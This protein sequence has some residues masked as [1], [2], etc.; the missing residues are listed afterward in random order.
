MLPSQINEIYKFPFQPMGHQ[1]ESLDA[2]YGSDKWGFYIF[3]GGG[4][5]Y[6]ATAAAL[7]QIYEGMAERCIII[8]PPILILQWCRWLKE[9]GNLNGGFSITAYKG[10]PKQREKLRLDSDFTVMSIQIFKRD[11]ARIKKQLRK[12]RVVLIVD[13]AQ[14]VRNVSTKNFRF[15]RDSAIEHV[16]YLLSGT[17]LNSPIN[18]Y[19]LIKLVT[20]DLYRSLGAFKN[21]HVATEDFWGAPKTYQNLDLLKSN[22]ELGATFVDAADA[23]D[24]PE[25]T[26]TPIVYDLAPAHMKLYN[27]LVDEEM[28]ILEDE[29][30]DA[31]QAMKLYHKCQELVI[32]PADFSDGAVKISAAF[33][34][35]DEILDEIGN[36][37]IIIF[38]HHR[39]SNSNI[40]THLANK[41]IKAVGVYGVNTP[42]VN[43]KNVDNFITDDTVQCLVA[44]TKSG[45][46]G[47]NL[48]VARY[49][50]FLECPLTSNDFQQTIARI[51][52]TGQKNGCTVWLII[53]N[54]T[55]QA[56]IARN[57][58]NRDEV[59][60]EVVQSKESISKALKGVV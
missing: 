21:I 13:E 30:V 29:V 58:T 26:Y 7:Y 14:M 1:I 28:L 52:R 18:A 51:H 54:N 33:E 24:L 19:A 20:P 48:Q 40:L 8:C 59:L 27:K 60:Q 43:Q 45:G 39:L 36:E 17:P 23:V 35:M 10:T 47:L 41:K 6:T 49:I 34:L 50:L 5:T 32:N 22:L 31:T 38:S 15:L 44:N 4:K 37:K 3:A 16:L 9:V 25:I 46:V 11:H 53:A 57:V 12:N 2:S 55:I 56:T 42:K